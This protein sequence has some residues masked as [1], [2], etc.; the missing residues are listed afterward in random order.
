MVRLRTIEVQPGMVTA[1]PVQDVKGRVLC[2]E[3]RELTAQLI[4]W[5]TDHQAA[6]V[7]VQTAEDEAEELVGEAGDEVEA[8]LQLVFAATEES[9]E[10]QA[11]RDQIAAHLRNARG[12]AA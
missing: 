4:T 12:L 10:M 2:P 7:F 5:L 6:F 11:L 1:R 8:R 9:P 3:G